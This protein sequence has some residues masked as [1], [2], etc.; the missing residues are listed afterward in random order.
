MRTMN[1][2]IQPHVGT[3]EVNGKRYNVAVRVAYDG[4]EFVGRLWFAEDDWDDAGTPDRGYLT[5]RTKEDVITIARSYSQHELAARCRRALSNKRRF[6]LLRKVTEEILAK[7]RYLNQLSVSMRAGLID[8]E[9]AA[10]EIDYTEQQ[11]HQL[12]R[13]LRA[14]AGVETTQA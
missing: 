12:V 9:G 11:L 5:G 3:I 14:A 8:L 1:E 7:V 10:Q 6:P 4:L 13:R 2:A